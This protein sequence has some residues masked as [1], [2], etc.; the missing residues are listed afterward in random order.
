MGTFPCHRTTF[1]S[2]LLMRG[3]TRCH[4]VR[5]DVF[6]RIS[7]HAPHARSDQ[8]ASP[9]GAAYRIS[10]HAPHAR[11]DAD[12]RM[13]D[14]PIEISIHA[15]HARSDKICG[16][17]IHAFYI[18]QSTL[19]MRGATSAR[20]PSECTER[21]QSTLLMR[22]ATKEIA[23][24]LPC[25]RISIHAPHARSDLSALTAPPRARYFNPRSS[26]EERRWRYQ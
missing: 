16:F 21:F 9:R 3:A 15:P 18:F 19:L 1:Q 25:R 7:I 14:Q 8:T 23:D 22:G 26:C 20:F 12:S 13:L 11:S 24:S 17:D 2:T 10:I 5:R 6:L 4:A